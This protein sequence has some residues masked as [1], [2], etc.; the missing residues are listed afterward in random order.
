[1]ACSARRQFVDYVRNGGDKPFISLQ[2]GSG[3][4]FEKKLAGK[5]WHSEGSLDDLI[6]AYE[7]VG[8]VPLFNTGLA[9]IERVVPKI[10]KNYINLK[11]APKD[12]VCAMVET[13]QNY[14]VAHQ[15]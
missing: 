13:I 15:I 14:S 1:M 5:N 7:K 12:N 2:I 9:N 4:G 3:A 8:S 11:A 6:D 10:G